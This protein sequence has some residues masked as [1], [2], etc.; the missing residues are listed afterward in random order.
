[1]SLLVAPLTGKV[2]AKEGPV[3]VQRPV[4]DKEASDREDPGVF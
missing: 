2:T 3:A 1:M 4:D